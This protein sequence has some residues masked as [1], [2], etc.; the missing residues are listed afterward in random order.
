MPAGEDGGQHPLPLLCAIH[1]VG[2]AR[3][4]PVTVLSQ[5]HISIILPHEC[6][7]EWL[8]Q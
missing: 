3:M 7:R 6:Q 5:V 8:G 2:L 4:N 1:T